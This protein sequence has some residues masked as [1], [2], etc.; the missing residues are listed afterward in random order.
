MAPPPAH[1]GDRRGTAMPPA[2][3]QLFT[4]E[5]V[6]IK[7]FRITL[8]RPGEIVAAA[9]VR[10]TK[11]WDHAV[12]N[13][14][15][16]SLDARFGKEG[17]HKNARCATCG[18]SW[19]QCSSHM[20][21]A[22][23][24]RGMALF[25]PT[26]AK[27]LAAVLGALSP[28]PAADGFYGADESG[29]LLAYH[30][31]ARTREKALAAVLKA[32]PEERLKM[33]RDHATAR[34]RGRGATKRARGVR[35]RVD[36]ANAKAVAVVSD[37]DV[38]QTMS[39]EAGEVHALLASLTAADLEAMGVDGGV[40]SITGIMFG[41]LPV[42]PTTMRPTGVR[43]GRPAYHAWTHA[44]NRVAG[45]MV[46]LQGQC[47]PEARAKHLV[48][49]Q[50]AVTT[51]VDSSVLATKGAA[52]KKATPAHQESM[53]ES[54][55]KKAGLIRG[56]VLGKRGNENARSVISPDPSLRHH[57]VGVPDSVCAKLCIPEPVNSWSR[58]HGG[59]T[60]GKWPMR[61]LT[62]SHIV[63]VL[64]QVQLT[65]RAL[66]AGNPAP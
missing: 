64:E 34:V 63:R 23:L 16:T 61:I 39:F 59:V 31:T 11:A 42:L 43:D 1:E 24:P 55:E 5:P 33:L 20:G 50:E 26:Y 54:T 65:T 60:H 25:N 51:M 53:K 19:R 48:A 17:I 66:L 14:A 35:W 30:G 4:A 45:A 47:T 49:A 40:G 12:D 7:A 38:A 6:S 57:Q 22:E 44:I 52:P 36:Y 28:T 27:Q 3:A 41:D 58:A 32:P 46:R 13:Y 10:V 56:N 15:G 18:L 9:P 62:D 8:L 37:G 21:A 2:T 29:L